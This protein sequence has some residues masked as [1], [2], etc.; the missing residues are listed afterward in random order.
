M[1]IPIQMASQLSG[2]NPHV[3]RIWER[4][5]NALNPSRT[6]TNRRM[7]CEEAIERLKLLRELTEAGHRI[8]N[9]A[10]LGTEDLRRLVDQQ[11]TR[12]AAP[13]AG[14]T[15]THAI[16][17]VEAV[18]CLEK[19]QDFIQCALEACG[20]YDTD[21]LR[22]L[23]LRARQQLGQRGMLHQVIC[24]LLE[25]MK[26]AAEAGGL[27]PAHE[28]IATSVI[29]EMLML[30]VPGS[31]TAPNAP[32]LMVA[33]PCGELQEIGAM[34]AAA[35]ARD[36]GWRITYLGPNLPVE[37]IAAC[38][39]ARRARAVALS[40]VYLEKCPVIEEK[41]LRLRRLLPESTAMIV[42]GKA[43]SGYEQL[44]AGAPIHWAHS[45]CELDQILL[46]VASR[47]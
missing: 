21:R 5:Y 23:L 9:V 12:T 29:R 31:Q 8:G 20:A 25:H 15:A 1:P 24:P 2:L 38:A 27:R 37:E 19:P 36:L 35:S 14:F 7:Y 13:V 45:L 3:I 32:E 4:R 44:L 34:M 41:L 46:Q 18:P 11:L 16:S 42:G 26:Q 28:C 39:Q 6:C 40:V 47:G 33:T 43:A 30:P 10:R 22:R 17:F